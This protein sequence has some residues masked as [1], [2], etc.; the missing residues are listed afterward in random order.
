MRAFGGARDAWIALGLT[1][2]LLVIYNANGREI[3]SYDSI[4]NKFAAREL[5]LRGTL[6]LNHVIGAVPQLADRE[7]FV[8][9][10][11]ALPH[12]LDVA[13]L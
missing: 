11:D 3:G 1:A 13:A 2:A 5:L 12:G 9:C 10:L 8:L 4:P 6:T 7:A